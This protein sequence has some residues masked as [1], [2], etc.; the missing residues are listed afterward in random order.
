MV[1]VQIKCVSH[2]ARKP[3]DLCVHTCTLEASCILVSRNF[4]VCFEFPRFAQGEGS[5]EVRGAGPQ[6]LIITTKFEG[7]VFGGHRCGGISDSVEIDRSS[8]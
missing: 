2:F 3:P 8:C 5:T 7:E 6:A 4:A 1:W